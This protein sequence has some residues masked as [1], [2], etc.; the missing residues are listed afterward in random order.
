MLGARCGGLMLGARRGGLMLG[1]RRFPLS[2]LAA[3]G[4]TKA[5]MRAVFS[6]AASIATCTCAAL[7]GFL[8]GG[9]QDSYASN[10][11]RDTHMG[12]VQIAAAASTT[13]SPFS[14]LPPAA[15][16]DVATLVAPTAAAAPAPID[17]GAARDAAPPRPV[18]GHGK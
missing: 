15:P 8:L 3:R 17:A 10:A 16:T 11:Q 7:A 2:R 1:A 13:M 9:C 4:C 5:R 12:E 18:R 6:G 14:G